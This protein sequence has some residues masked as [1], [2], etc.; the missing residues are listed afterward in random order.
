MSDFVK[1]RTCFDNGFSNFGK[2][3][4]FFK[5]QKLSY[6]IYR[7]LKTLRSK[8]ILLYDVSHTQLCI[9]FLNKYLSDTSGR[10]YDNGVSMGLMSLGSSSLAYRMKNFTLEVNQTDDV[11]H[12]SC[13]EA[14]KEA[15]YHTEPQLKFEE[16]D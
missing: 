7:N 15:S 8:D 14:V 16:D 9:D 1:L 13:F 3:V 6:N 5:K 11:A 4:I 10:Q 12:I 2:S